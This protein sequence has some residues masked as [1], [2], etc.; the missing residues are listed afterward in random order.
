M[1]SIPQYH[2]CDLTAFDPI[3][4]EL[5]RSVQEEGLPRPIEHIAV[6]HVWSRIIER[7]NHRAAE[8]GVT[9]C[10]VIDTLAEENEM[11]ERRLEAVEAKRSRE[12]VRYPTDEELHAYLTAQ[13]FTEDEP[14]FPTE[15]ELHDYLCRSGLV[16]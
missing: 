7:F 13:G 3:I 11:L 14:T 4:D 2:A 10:P 16:F 15:D 8:Q 5:I 1:T 9:A 12:R 6:G